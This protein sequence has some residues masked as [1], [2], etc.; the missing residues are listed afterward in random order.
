MTTINIITPP[1]KI[2]NDAEKLLLIYPTNNLQTELQ[3]KVLSH[4][5]Y[6]LDLYVFDLQNPTDA[7]IDWLLSV[8]NLV[9][10]IIVDI[11][12]CDPKIK[13]LLGYILSKSRTYW[14]TNAD[15]PVYNHIN[16][17]QIFN[18]DNFHIGGLSV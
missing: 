18:L 6:D 8:V 7:D 1:D 2:F 14:L 16:R 17:K 13:Q 3:E 12:N 4:L 10:T 5:E 9:N 15:N 11:D